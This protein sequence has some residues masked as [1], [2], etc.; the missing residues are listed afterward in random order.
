VSYA[1]IDDVFGRFPAIATNVGTGQFEVTSDDVSSVFIAQAEG[2]VNAYLAQRYLVPL[3]T[4]SLSPLITMITAD[5]AICDML[6]D[7]LPQV[8]E[9]AQNRCSKAMELLEKIQSGKLDL[10]LATETTTPTDLEIWSNT[11]NFHPIFNPVLKPTQETVDTDRV[12][13]AL[14]DR[15]DDAGLLGSRF[16]G[17]PL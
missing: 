16:W 14:G 7:K 17:Q 11:M 3:G 2:I 4:A 9:F 10:H 13:D 6:V 1:T 15:D 8:P 5:I 12:E